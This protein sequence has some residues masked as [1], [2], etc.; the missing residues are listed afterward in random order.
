[1]NPVAD[2]RARIGDMESVSDRDGVVRFDIP[3]KDQRR[4]YAIEIEGAG[5]LD[6]IEAP[7][8]ENDVLIIE[9]S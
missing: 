5:R 1:M 4:F 6:T 8:G 9:E 3:L 2:R 7:T